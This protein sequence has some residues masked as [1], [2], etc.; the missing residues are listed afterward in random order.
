[1]LIGAGTKV[2]RYGGHA[3]PL[4]AGL[5]SMYISSRN[6]RVMLAIWEVVA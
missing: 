5:L 4:P 3:L 2:A 1:M 6:R